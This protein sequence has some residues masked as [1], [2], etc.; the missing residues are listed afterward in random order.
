MSIKIED[1][2]IM[3]EDE[4]YLIRRTSVIFNYIIFF[5]KSNGEYA[6]TPKEITLGIN[7][8]YLFGKKPLRDNAV[9]NVLSNYKKKK[10]NTNITAIKVKGI[11]Y[12]YEK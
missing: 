7:E 5:L 4:C 10:L 8:Q 12:W 11:Y 1:I 6:F 2:K 9:N 3:T